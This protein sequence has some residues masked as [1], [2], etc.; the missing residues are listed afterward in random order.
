MGLDGIGPLKYRF[1]ST[2]NATVLYRQ[3]LVESA[4]AE[5]GILTNHVNGG[6]TLNYTGIFDCAERGQCPNPWIVQG[7]MSTLDMRPVLNTHNV[8]I[9]IHSMDYWTTLLHFNAR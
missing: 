7:Q 2:A 5:P 9:F 6:A 3:W 4:D 1:F 8:N